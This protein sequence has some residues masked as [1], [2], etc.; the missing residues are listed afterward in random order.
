[1]PPIR[2]LNLFSPSTKSLMPITEET[3][4][5]RDDLQHDCCS[6]NIRTFFKDSVQKFH[7][8]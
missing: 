1:M 3:P 2:Y 7:L 4:K 5:A 6:D 8:L